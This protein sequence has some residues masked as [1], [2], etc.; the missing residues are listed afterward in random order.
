M[1]KGLG[2]GE[3]I[4]EFHS[5][6]DGKKARPVAVLEE[7]LTLSMRV[8]GSNVDRIRVAMDNSHHQ[9]G[10]RYSIIEVPLKNPESWNRI[11]VRLD[12]QSKHRPYTQ[13]TSLPLLKMGDSIWSLSFEAHRADK[14]KPEGFFYL[15]D[16]RL[17]T[18]R[19]DD[20][21]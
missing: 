1:G 15:D 10:D 21:E 16:I 19:E 9:E 6:A 3:M 18:G 4:D 7:H 14:G 5:E 20:D 2:W 8:R 13:G 17:T 11:K 12:D